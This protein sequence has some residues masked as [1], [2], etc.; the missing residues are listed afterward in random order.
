L[1]G[2]EDVRKI[3]GDDLRR[4]IVQLQEKTVW[5]GLPQNQGR[6]LSPTSVNTYVRAIKSFWS[7][8]QREGII[9]YNPLASI[10]CPKAPRKLPKVYSEDQLKS[11]LR[12][13]TL[14]WRNRAIIELL[15]DSGIR[16]SELTRLTINDIDTK[17]GT[18]RVV[19]KGSKERYSYFS[20]RTAL[21]LCNYIDSNR[22]RPA[23][24]DNLFL[25]IDGNPLTNNRVQIILE[26][27]GKKAGISERLSAHKLRH[28]YATMSLKHGNNLEYIRITLGH[29][30]IKTTSDAYLAAVDT[31]IAIAHRKYSPMA[32]LKV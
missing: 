8:L 17:Q 12:T 14:S 26:R 25:T 5:E 28:T 7:W 31:D 27:I 10:P 1:G 11:V 9:K 32:N 15:L 22:P 29:S 3:S 2:I 30:D 24:E 13:S 19:G 21:A 23:R 20:P 6:R 18:V 4:F 16:L